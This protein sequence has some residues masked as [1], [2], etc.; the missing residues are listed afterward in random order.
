MAELPPDAS[1]EL[2]AAQ[3]ATLGAARYLSAATQRLG[4]A[5]RAG[6]FCRGFARLELE[7]RVECFQALMHAM[8]KESALQAAEVL[9]TLAPDPGSTV[10]RITRHSAEK[11]RRGILAKLAAE[12]G[13]EDWQHMLD[14]RPDPELAAARERSRGRDLSP[15]PLGI[16]S[17]SPQTERVVPAAL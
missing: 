7:H 16:P 10:L 3:M 8:P 17:A 9:L 13:P 12:L 5:E 14:A 6:L 2:L 4:S 15:E 1:E 11:A